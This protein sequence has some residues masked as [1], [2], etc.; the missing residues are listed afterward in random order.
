MRAPEWDGPLRWIH[1]DLDRRN[2]LVRDGRLAAVLDWEGA[3]AGD[4]AVDVMVA[5]KLVGCED[6]ERFRTLVGADDETWL[7]A[8]GWCVSQ[9]LIA[10]GYYT[11]E[12]NPPIHAA[13]TRWLAEVLPS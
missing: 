2:V 1:C 6:R 12:N 13:A 7:R 10:L 8:K 3:G 4:P 11:S 9:A 5:W